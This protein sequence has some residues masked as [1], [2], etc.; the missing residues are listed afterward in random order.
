MEM[1]VRPISL[2][3]ELSHQLDWRPPVA[4][5]VIVSD[6]EQS[7]EERS[8]WPR[9]CLSVGL[10]T[11]QTT[12]PMRLL[13]KTVCR[14][15]NSMLTKVYLELCRKWTVVPHF[16]FISKLGKRHLKH[17]KGR[18][19]W[20]KSPYCYLIHYT[21]ILICLVGFELKHGWSAFLCNP[22]TEL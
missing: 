17:L 21:I 13:L 7:R 8:S 16:K 1:K 10:G 12:Q 11:C 18:K 9:I 19:E 5:S 14:F 2:Q 6:S 20:Q 22:S 15:S 3:H 4:I